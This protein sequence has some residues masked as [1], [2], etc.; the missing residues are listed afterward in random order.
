MSS[1]LPECSRSQRAG[2]ASARKTNPSG[3]HYSAAL[4]SRSSASTA[5]SGARST[6]SHWTRSGVGAV[7]PV[8]ERP[9]P[10]F[11]FFFCFFWWGCVGARRRRAAARG[12]RSPRWGASGPRTAL[13][14]RGG[15]AAASPA[16]LAPPATPPAPVPTQH[17]RSPP[18]LTAPT[19]ALTRHFGRIVTHTL[20]TQPHTSCHLV[21]PQRALPLPAHAH[22]NAEPQRC[23]TPAY[24]PPAHR[25]PAP[26]THPTPRTTHQRSTNMHAVAYTLYHTHQPAPSA[27]L[28]N[29]YNTPPHTPHN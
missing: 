26:T 21:A 10:F 18:P 25:T 2:S 13:H 22:A 29:H 15:S 23:S 7:R 3:S 5:G 6:R 12:A 8:A 11:F 4:A 17:A 16:A 27:T 19:P 1:R 24:S 9:E 14:Q 20:P 28:L